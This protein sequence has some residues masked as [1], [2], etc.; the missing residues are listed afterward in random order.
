MKRGF[1]SKLIISVL[2]AAMGVTGAF[3]QSLSASEAA[4]L[5]KKTDATTAFSGTDFTANYALVQEKPGQGKS[6][7]TAI[8]Y[9][10]DDAS[11]YTILITGPAS[12][13]GKGYVQFDQNIWFY[14]PADKQ[15]VFSSSKEKL[16]GT[17]ATTA[18]FTPQ[19]YSENYR[20]KS[21]TK[22]KLGSLKCVV[23]DLA[24]KVDDV[25]YPAVKLW[26]TEDDGLIRKKEDYSL[27]GQLLR[28]TAIP[29]YQVYTGHSVPKQMLIIDNL[30]GKKI[31]NKMQYEQTQIT[32]SNVSFAKQS[33]TVYTKKYV[34]MMSSK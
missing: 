12:D 14:D 4:A 6:E 15:F 13:R 28:T 17:N 10:R 9:R 25:N 33:N 11:S 27:S 32:I 24:A 19:H 29:S 16:Q 31:N 7:N 20:I 22:E 26:V 2:I 5:L 34:E 30:R 8:M 3:A 18:D 23:F 1:T 21:A